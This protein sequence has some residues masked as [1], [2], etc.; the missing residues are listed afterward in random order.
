[1]RQKAVADLAE[2][3]ANLRAANL[4][5][6][7]EKCIFGVHK[8]KVLS[9]LVFTKGIEAN[10]DK[11]KALVNME[12]QQTIRDMQK[13]TRRIVALN[14]FI[15]CP[16]DRSLSF[17]KVLYNSSKFDWGNN[18]LI[19]YL[20]KMTKLTAPEPKDTLLLYISA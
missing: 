3:F 17:F 18:S 10:P 1:M 14:R 12:G 20:A 8:G 4:R 7:P 9:F 15:P 11:I 13:L 2:T 6:N 19:D 5:L 16:A